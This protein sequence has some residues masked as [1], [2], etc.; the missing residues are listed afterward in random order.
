MALPKHPIPTNDPQGLN[1]LNANLGHLSTTL[2]GS[3]ED[4]TRL[5]AATRRSLSETAALLLDMSRIYPGVNLTVVHQTEIAAA[6][7]N[8]NPWAW[9]RGRIR[10]GNF[11]GINVGDFIPLAINGNTYNMEI[12]GINTYERYGS[13]VVPRHI[14]LISRELWPDP[15]QYNLANYNNG[16][17]AMTTPFLASH[18]NA[19]INSLQA[20]VPNATTL[21]PALA[22]VDFRSGGILS[23]IPA[24][25]RAVIVPKV[26]LMARRHSATVLLTDDNSWDWRT[27]GDLWLPSEIEVAG[28][29]VWGS[30]TS[31]L[32]GFGAGGYV[33]Y[34]LFAE[35]MKR[36]KNIVGT[37]TRASWWL[38][39]AVGGNSTGAAFVGSSGVVSHT[40]A[41]YAGVRVPVCFRIA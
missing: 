12:A 38:V 5:D 17:T 20:D 7:F 36:L 29:T 8:G 16:I 28:H 19:F 41:T 3:L 11:A 33:H 23:R 1:H 31:G 15:I 25:A 39:S 24:E 14:D 27:M 35:N 2:D 18:I 30:T 4:I 40:S 9:L 26:V 10:A 6:P 37:A 22:S 13:P 32:H 21:N 34:P